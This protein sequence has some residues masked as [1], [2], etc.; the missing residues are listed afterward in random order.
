M[1]R[2]RGSNRSRL[3]S[4]G[5]YDDTATATKVMQV[6]ELYS[7]RPICGSLPCDSIG[8]L[9]ATHFAISIGCP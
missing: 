6:D 8:D 5:E 9:S 1:A 7:N 3:V 2:D 4:V